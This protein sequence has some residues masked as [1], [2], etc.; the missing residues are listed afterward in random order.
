M[1][2]QNKE[3]VDEINEGLVSLTLVMEIKNILERQEQRLQEQSAIL[4]MIVPQKVSISYLAE[5]TG[6]T[7]Q[8]IR[9]Y[10]ITHFNPK[11]DFWKEGG[12][13]FVSRSVATEI[14]MKRSA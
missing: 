13:L 2:N 5:T 1:K 14:L 4:N 6:K 7:R 12:K 8:G 3:M 10:V 11:R 9:D